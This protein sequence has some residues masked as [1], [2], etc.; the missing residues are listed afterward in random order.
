MY[1]LLSKIITNQGLYM[2]ISFMEQARACIL[3]NTVWLYDCAC[4]IHV[5]L[6][7]FTDPTLPKEITA[8]TGLEKSS[9]TQAETLEETSNVW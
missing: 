4:I 9:L 8:D 7:N 6:Y 3:G 5:V 2:G 1:I